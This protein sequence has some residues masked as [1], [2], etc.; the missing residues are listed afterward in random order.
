MSSR[1]LLTLVLLLGALLGGCNGDDPVPDSAP[2]GDGAMC[3]G[4]IAYLQA[5]MNDDECTSCT[6]RSFGHSKVCTKTCNGPEDCPAPSGGC[7]NGLCRP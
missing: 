2:T 7:S 5:C 3:A 1:I 6:C 4:T